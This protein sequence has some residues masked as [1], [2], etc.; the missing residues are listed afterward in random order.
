MRSASSRLAPASSSGA[1]VCVGVVRAVDRGVQQLVLA[2]IAS[3]AS[4]A[5]AVV[6]ACGA[7]GVSGSST[8]ASPPVGTVG[9]SSSVRPAHST[10][11]SFGSFRFTR[12]VGPPPTSVVVSVANCTGRT[13]ASGGSC[14]VG[15][16]GV[17]EGPVVAIVCAR[18]LPAGLALIPRA[19]RKRL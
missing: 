16:T 1:R 15:R 19:N 17:L 14:V 4:A 9:P 12:R 8:T 2:S 10:R 7:R 6:G 11:D 3:I 5:A 13:G 18:A